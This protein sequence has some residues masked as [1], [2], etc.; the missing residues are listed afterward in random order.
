VK[1]GPKQWGAG[2]NPTGGL[3][4]N[5]DCDTAQ[6]FYCYGS[7][8][9]DGAAYCTRYGCTSD[10]ECAPNFYCGTIN[11]APNVTTA[12][13]TRHQTTKLCLRRDYCAPC[14]ADLDC[15]TLNGLTQHCVP[16]SVT[17]DGLCAPECK[18]SA[19]CNFEA[20]CVDVGT[21]VKTCYPRAG[22]C[23]GDGSLCSPCSNDGDCGDDGLCVKGQYTTE[24]SCAKKSAVTCSATAKQCP[25]SSA[26]KAKIGCSTQDSE[27]A[28]ANY[29]LGLWAF[30]DGAD[31]G[32]WTPAR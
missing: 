3:E 13:P 21:G 25:P 16:D 2:C 10:R 6:G 11:V 24:H 26:A 31:I 32:C 7:S 29:C 17:G 18:S 22:A 5:P 27:E 30:G 4:A 20:R 14:A 8:P 1:A 15:P 23:K 19:N 9:A 28:P 12:K